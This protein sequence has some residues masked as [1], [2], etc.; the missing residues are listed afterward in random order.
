MGQVQS[1]VVSET[2]ARANR[3]RGTRAGALLRYERQALATFGPLAPD[4][5]A[6]A[7]ARLRHQ[8]ALS[9]AQRSSDAKRRKAAG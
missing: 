7:A 9:L 6:E 1:R 4:A 5:L 2:T 8:W 3:G